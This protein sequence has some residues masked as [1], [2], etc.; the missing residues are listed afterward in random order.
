MKEVE[1]LVWLMPP[2]FTSLLLCTCMCIWQSYLSISRFP[3]FLYT[4][5]IYNTQLLQ[6]IHLLHYFFIYYCQIVFLCYMPPIA[7]QLP[8]TTNL[9]HHILCFHTVITQIL[10]QWLSVCQFIN[11]STHLGWNLNLVMHPLQN[12][13]KLCLMITSV[14]M[15]IFYK[16]HY[17]NTGL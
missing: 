11:I 4:T 10:L 12:M 9:Q 14:L 17:N 2:L 13:F 15:I 8:S 3:I 5:S 7:R 1:I 16:H 6:D